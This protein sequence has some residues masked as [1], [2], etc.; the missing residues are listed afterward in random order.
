MNLLEREADVLKGGEVGEKIVG[1]ED[2]AELLAMGAEAGFIGRNEVPI[3]SDF[4]G[5]RQVEPGEEAQESGFSAARGADEREGVIEFDFEVEGSKDALP[6][7][8]FGDPAEGDSHRLRSFSGTSSGISAKSGR[9]TSMISSTMAGSKGTS[10]ASS[11][12]GFNS[13]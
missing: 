3:D 9:G 10:G 11:G 7:V 2:D 8:G 5:V 6:A 1:L 12:A 13:K 4:T